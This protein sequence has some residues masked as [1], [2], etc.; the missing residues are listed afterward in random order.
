MYTVRAVTLAILV[1]L[2]ASAGIAQSQQR[3]PGTAAPKVLEVVRDGATLL[4]L[5]GSELAE[6]PR[7]ALM[8]KDDGVDVRYEGVWIHEIL[9]RAGLPLGAKLRGE[10]MLIGVVAEANDDY[11]VL[12]TLAEID[13]AFREPHVLV[14]DRLDGKPLLAHQGPIRLVVGGDKR[15]ARSVRM[16]SRLRVV[17]VEPSSR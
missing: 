17:T 15:G 1:V 7:A 5:S 3:M 4:H 16:L 9:Q 11:R 2:A 6:F 14:A 13:A 8:M 10:A 12:F